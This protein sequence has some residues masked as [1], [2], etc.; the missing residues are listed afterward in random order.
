[1]FSQN[2]ISG[3]FVIPVTY[4]GELKVCT[5]LQL[6]ANYSEVW[7]FFVNIDWTVGEGE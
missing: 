3:A 7:T 6:Y 2:G 5:N 1:M 4:N